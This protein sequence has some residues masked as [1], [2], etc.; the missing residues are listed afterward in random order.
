MLFPYQVDVPMKRW[1]IAN[2]AIL[3]T[4]VI[5]F[6]LENGASTE[7][8]V[9]LILH[10]WSFSGLMGYMWLHTGIIHLVGNGLFLWVFGNAVCAKVGN[11]FYPLIYIGLG[12]VAGMAHLVFDGSPVVGA[13]GAINGVV[14]M[15]LVLYPLNRISC[16]YWIFIKFGTFSFG[17][18]WAILLWLIFDVWGAFG[19]S[20]HTAYLAHLGGF[21]AGFA[22]AATLVWT[23]LLEMESY[24][25]SL[26][27]I[28]GLRPREPHAPITMTPPAPTRNTGR[29]V[30]GQD[31][32]SV[33]LPPPYETSEQG[34]LF[35]RC[36][37]GK[38]LKAS[39]RLAGKTV[40]CPVCTKPIVIAATPPT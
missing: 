31:S 25:R 3:G 37:C 21:A 14:G 1:P 24:E 32:E 38:T 34:H 22:L 30:R 33:S 7:D 36:S 20:D 13:S 6:A 15:Y 16:A 35:V 39:R 40:V 12:L 5:A 18:F 29:T 8:L 27:Q 23:R 2:W 26:V 10:D 28:F 4:M 9:P 17:S 19:R 11:V